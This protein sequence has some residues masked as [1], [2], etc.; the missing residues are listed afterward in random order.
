[1]VNDN[2]KS[3]RVIQE[4]GID[5]DT[6]GEAIPWTEV[7]VKIKVAFRTKALKLLK[8][9]KLSCF[10][11]VALHVGEEGTAYPSIDTIMRETGYSR[12]VVCNALKKLED[13]GFIEKQRR[14]HA[15]TLYSVRGYVWFGSE[16]KPTLLGEAQSKKNELSESQSR[17]S[18]CLPAKRLESR[19]KDDPSLKDKPQTAKDNLDSDSENSQPASSSPFQR[20]DDFL[21]IASKCAQSPNYATPPSA[22]GSD[23]LGDR[24]CEEFAFCLRIPF[25]KGEERDQWRRAFWKVLRKKGTTD[26]ELAEEAL[27]IVLDPCND[28]FNWYTYTEPTVVKFQRDFGLVLG[29]LMEDAKTADTRQTR[30]LAQAEASQAALAERLAA[31]G[32]PVE[33]CAVGQA[34][35]NELVLQ[36]TRQVFDTYVKP[37]SIIQHDG[38]I[39]VTAPDE[40][41]RDWLENRI[42]KTIQRTAVGVLGK[43]VEVE[44]EVKL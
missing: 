14:K 10:L 39:L 13:L 3:I 22:G 12:S 37:A 38:V 44:F 21:T 32:P 41:G 24:L 16:S 30:D 1:M 4:R 28:E 42:A 9:P 34:V 29:R 20:G 31:R 17:E 5:Y 25:P 2:E 35:K 8:G 26:G 36:M 7:Y 15:S 19:L 23:V 33:D 27:R 11:C 6:N 18:K 43:A 40:F